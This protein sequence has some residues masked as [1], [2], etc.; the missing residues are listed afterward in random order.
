MTL[1]M[2]SQTTTTPKQDRRIKAIFT[3]E[4]IIDISKGLSNE[5]RQRLQIDSLQ[6]IIALKENI[7]EQLKQEHLTTLTEIAKSNTIAK[8]ST[9]EVDKISDEQLK[10]ERFKWAGL[11]LYGGFETPKIDFRNI[12]LNMELMYEFE[13]FEFGVKGIGGAT[14]QL[15]KTEFVFDYFIKVRY[16]FF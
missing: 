3:P 4:K 8:E 11:H 15:D 1:S 9:E 13:R 14:E 6:K 12:E 5:E 10:K 2:S 16:K 7:I